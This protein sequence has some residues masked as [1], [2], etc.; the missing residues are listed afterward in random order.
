MEVILLEQIENLGALGD[1]VSVKAGY[2]RNYLLPHGKALA[3]TAANLETFEARRAELEKKAVDAL[4]RAQAR[5]AEFADIELT[6]EANAGP[7]GKLFG[8]VGPAE[9]A[10][11]LTGKGLVVEKQ[12]VRLVEAIRQTGEFNVGLHMH[13]EVDVEIVVIVAELDEV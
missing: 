10:A 11:A 12:E 7:G 9:I 2:G 8:S 1:K 6:I 4:T 13:N 3:A 5:A